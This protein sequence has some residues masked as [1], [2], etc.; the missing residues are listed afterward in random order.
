M[1]AVKRCPRC[2]QVKLA[3]EFYRRQRTR[4]SAYCRACQQAAA[5]AARR[6]RRRDPIAVDQL[7]A[8]DRT[9]QRRHRHLG[10]QDRSGG[11]AA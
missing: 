8:V 6:R 9:R 5:R 10:G 2:G 11:D 3:S 7:R 1:T 4:L